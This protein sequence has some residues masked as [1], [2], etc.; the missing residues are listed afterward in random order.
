MSYE[1]FFKW[2]SVKSPLEETDQE[3]DVLEKKR[4]NRLKLNKHINNFVIH[5][6]ILI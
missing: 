4:S 2:L 1:C 6:E 3:T 5:H